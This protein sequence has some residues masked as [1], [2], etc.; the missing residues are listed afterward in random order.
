MN[1]AG[2]PRDYRLDFL[3][4]S[5]LYYLLSTMDNSLLQIPQDDFTRAEV[6]NELWGHYSDPK[7]EH[8]LLDLSAFWTYYN[9]ECSHALHDAGRHVSA[10][11]HRDILEVARQ[12]KADKDRHEIK[13]CLRLKLAELH[14]N[15]DEL[16]E[17]TIDLAASLLLMCDCGSSSSHGFSGR[18]E[19]GWKEGQP[20][21]QFLGNYFGQ[22]PMLISERVK[23]EKSFTSHNLKRIASVKIIWTDNLADHL[24]LIDDDTKVLVFHHASFLE[25]CRGR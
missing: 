4:V 8:F 25:R 18:T 5:K 10:R 2:S 17:N 14:D 19:L 11:T 1:K 20:I 16:L 15:E 24:R 7:L 3:R 6:A 23:L 12:L 22:Q 13:K 21:R 9:N